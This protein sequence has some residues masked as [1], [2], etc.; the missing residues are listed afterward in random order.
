ML[1]LLLRE[2]YAAEGLV[3]AIPNIIHAPRPRTRGLIVGEGVSEGDLVIGVAE[4]EGNRIARA[5]CPANP[6]YREAGGG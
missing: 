3:F 5:L 2:P 4:D 1:A 6:V